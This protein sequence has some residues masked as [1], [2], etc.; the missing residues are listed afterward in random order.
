MGLKYW[1][2][3]IDVFSRYVFLQLLK[4]KRSDYVSRKF[5]DILKSSGEVPEKI[6]SD[7]GTEFVESKNDSSKK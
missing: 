4:N 1:L 7:E 5:E 3:W 6:Q 2:V